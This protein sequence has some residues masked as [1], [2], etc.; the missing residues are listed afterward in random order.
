MLEPGF[1]STRCKWKQLSWRLVCLFW[2]K[3]SRSTLNLFFRYWTV[4]LVMELGSKIRQLLNFSS[5]CLYKQEEKYWKRSL[6]S[7]VFPV[8]YQLS[9]SI[10]VSIAKTTV[11]STFMWLFSNKIASRTFN[12][13]IWK[14]WWHMY[15]HVWVNKTRKLQIDSLIVMNYGMLLQN[16]TLRNKYQQK[17][18]KL[19]E[20][21]FW[22]F[23]IW[24]SEH[25]CYTNCLHAFLLLKQTLF[26]FLKI[27]TIPL[28]ETNLQERLHNAKQIILQIFSDNTLGISWYFVSRLW[29][30]FQKL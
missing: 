13:K 6:A 1:L 3:A 22:L 7:T 25:L 23:G 11:V 16:S 21:D 18:G 12:L 17:L 10:W 24:L 20:T 30:K 29:S 15:L 9:F 8:W 19:W 2:K 27:S 28:R 14:V 4:L 26:L 5:D